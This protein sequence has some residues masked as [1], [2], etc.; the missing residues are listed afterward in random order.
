M[1]PAKIESANPLA[2]GQFEL[3][4]T[5]PVGYDAIVEA[6]SDWQQWTPVATNRF[7]NSAVTC[8][9]SSAAQFNMRF[10]RVRLQ[11]TP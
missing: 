3:H 11:S 5:G 8:V 9:D 7:E 10:Y 6:T 2:D 1:A 4:L